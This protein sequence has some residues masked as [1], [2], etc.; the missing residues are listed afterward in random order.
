MRKNNLFWIL[1]LTVLIAVFVPTLVQQGMF[2]DGITYS[3]I[4]KNMA[5]GLGSFFDP[6][7]TQT[8]Y[9]HFREHPPLVFIIQ[10]GFFRLFG[11]GFYTERIFS[12]CI[13]LLT[14]WGINLC[15][16]LVHRK[17]ELENY[18]WFLVLLW[19][20]IPL[21]IWAYK[22]NLL[23]NTLSVFTLLSVYFLLRSL[24]DKKVVY[25]IPACI[26]IAA[27]FLSKG[28]VGLFP[29]AVPG[30]YALA[31]RRYRHPVIYSIYLL[32]LLTLLAL[33][34]A[35]AFPELKENLIQYF[36]RQLIPAL[37]NKREVTTHNRLSILFDLVFELTL[38]IVLLIAFGVWHRV[39]SKKGKY[40]DSKPALLFLLI[41]IAASIPL[42]VTL[43]QRKYYL[44]PSIPFYLLA[45]ASI[46]APV[47]KGFT[48]QLSQMTR[49]WVRR[50]SLF[51]AAVLIVVAVFRYGTYSRDTQKLGDVYTLS[52]LLPEGTV[53]STTDELST[54]WSLNAYMSRVGYLSL[55]CCHQHTYYLIE[56]NTSPAAEIEMKY[57]PVNLKLSKYRFYKKK[58]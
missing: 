39:K 41:A 50:I 20:T 10:S 28:F 14:V 24:I 55:D 7:Y 9:P 30:M 46:I 29:L 5:N 33:G 31:Y 47:I 56:K 25:L 2:L 58:E 16:R 3:A 38:P 12:F 54:D 8:L 51:A 44:I 18:G 4:S 34:L 22:N 26:C 15:W 48:D 57:Q 1:T 27:A 43:K 49:I 19:L 13:I 45:I 6:H 17:S 53:I 35:L 21:D 36:D 40:L 37:S 52:K 42:I 23:E 32:L 11:D